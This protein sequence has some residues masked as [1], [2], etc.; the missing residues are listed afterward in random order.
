MSTTQ[1]TSLVGLPSST[2]IHDVNV[3]AKYSNSQTQSLVNECG[4]G[5]SIGI[6]CAN[7]GPLTQGDSNTIAPTTSQISNPLSQISNPI[8]EGPPGPLGPQG[9]QGATGSQGPK[10]D[11]G[12]NGPAFVP[13]IYRVDG[14]SETNIQGSAGTDASIAQCDD[15]DLL[16]GGGYQGGQ[17]FGN[18]QARGVELIRVDAVPVLQFPPPYFSVIVFGNSDVGGVVFAKA[19]ALCMDVTP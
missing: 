14:P 9:P 1:L 10:G 18:P 2:V 7:T 13:K 8:K 11:K 3:Y 15:G 19:Y 12:D 6:N 17:V 5:R 4:S 16:V